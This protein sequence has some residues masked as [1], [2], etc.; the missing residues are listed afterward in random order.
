MCTGWGTSGCPPGGVVSGAAWSC[1]EEGGG[2]P[3][4]ELGEYGAGVAGGVMGATDADGG[5]VSHELPGNLSL[6]EYLLILARCHLSSGNMLCPSKAEDTMAASSCWMAE[7]G[8]KIHPDL[9]QA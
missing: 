1:G 6:C 2:V 5:T 4:A 8:G 3:G 9:V 7:Y